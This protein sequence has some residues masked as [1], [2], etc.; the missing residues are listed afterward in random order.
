[1]AAKRI[2]MKVPSGNAFAVKDSLPADSRITKGPDSDI[3]AVKVNIESPDELDGDQ[4]DHILLQ[5]RMKMLASSRGSNLN[6]SEGL[7][8]LQ[9][10]VP[11]NLEH[12]SVSVVDAKPSGLTAHQIKEEPIEGS[13]ESTYPSCSPGYS[14]V[15]LKSES[16]C[17]TFPEKRKEI[18]RVLGEKAHSSCPDKC[19]PIDSVNTKASCFSLRRKRKKT[20]TDSIETALEEDAPGL[21]QVLMER[22]IKVDELR[23][24]GDLEDEVSF[25]ISDNEDGFAELETV[26]T[27]MQILIV[28]ERPEY[29]Y[30]TYFF[31]IV[32]SLPI[33]WQI[34]RLVT[35]M[36]LESFS[37][38]TLIENKPLLVEED[39]TEGEAKVLE[40]YGWTQNTGLG[41]MLQFCD[42]VVHDRKNEGDISVW[43]CK[44]GKLLMDGFDGGSIVL[45]D[46]PKKFVDYA[47]GCGLQIKLIEAFYSGSGYDYD[48]PTELAL[49]QKSGVHLLM[50]QVSEIL[51]AMASIA[52]ICFR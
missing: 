30:A 14:P 51:R 27:K 25:D 7:N 46:L 24:Y 49:S 39:L 32:E 47:G 4:L 37:R 18:R 35:T 17:L 40:E 26:I 38:A 42:R 9:K 10:S 34:K 16:S 48:I 11:C 21:L 33:N 20:V 41:T 8:C 19:D 3:A 15:Q 13:M 12:E 43:R 31:K 36:K 28:V 45:F 22:G 29:G 1:M 2:K 50:A 23:L 52:N 44:I 6:F 5:E